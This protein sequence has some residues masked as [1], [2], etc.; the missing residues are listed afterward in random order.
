M[1]ESSVKVEVT[2]G[3]LLYIMSHRVISLDV[4]PWQHCNMYKNF[5]F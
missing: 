2:G 5:F 1:G 4:Q 3:E